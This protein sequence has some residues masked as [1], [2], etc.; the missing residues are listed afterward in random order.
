MLFSELLVEMSGRLII[1]LLRH[2]ACRDGDIYRGSTD[3]LL[4]DV[5][6]QQMERAFDAVAS[7]PYRALFSSPLQRCLLPAQRLSQR[8]VLPLEEDSRL[9]EID[10]GDWDGQLYATVWQHSQQKVLD[11]WNDPAANPPPAGESL[12]A[13]QRRLRAFVEQRVG[14][15]LKLQASC[16]ADVTESAADQYLLCLCHGGVIRA[17]L[18]QL[19]AMPFAVAQK[20]SL[21]YGSLT[22]IE[23]YLD[24]DS[25]A[26]DYQSQLVFV[27]RLPTVESYR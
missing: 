16:T 8:L 10:F 25:A 27:N 11:F 9:R 18:A 13:L 23:L 19:L 7:V 24:A 6:W 26:N 5:G 4:S 3:S 21:D 20:I 12:Q 15:Q 14:P 17:L 22:R 1:D 2:G